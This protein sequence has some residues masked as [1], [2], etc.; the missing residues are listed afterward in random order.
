[1][2]FDEYDVFQ[3]FLDGMDPEK[4]TDKAPSEINENFVKGNTIYIQKSF[5]DMPMYE[6]SKLRQRIRELI[7]RAVTDGFT[8]DVSAR[9]DDST[10]DPRAQKIFDDLS[11]ASRSGIKFNI[12]GNAG[13]WGDFIYDD[14]PLFHGMK[15][16]GAMPDKSKPL[17][18]RIKLFVKYDHIYLQ[19]TIARKSNASIAGFVRQI[20][21]AIDY[22]ID[23]HASI[24]TDTILPIGWEPV[25]YVPT[26]TIH[27]NCPDETSDS[28]QTKKVLTK[29]ESVLQ[30][31]IQIKLE[32][33]NPEQP[34]VIYRA[35]EQLKNRHMQSELGN[36]TR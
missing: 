17:T 24:S 12:R 30:N 27:T 28:V 35:I 16:L 32:P 19:D 18:E 15:F 33:A 9:C 25:K 8:I 7:S 26:V 34:D 20:D 23:M 5:A 1:M 6:I 2:N 10:I 13:A 22:V 11:A 3:A 21:R 31:G 14:D 36:K 4:R 29:L